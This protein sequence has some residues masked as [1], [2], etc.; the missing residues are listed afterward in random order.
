MKK[1]GSSSQPSPSELGGFEY[2]SIISAI[3]F[4]EL[5]LIPI[6]KLWIGH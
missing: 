1:K 6:S 5:V 3:I 4:L 2:Q